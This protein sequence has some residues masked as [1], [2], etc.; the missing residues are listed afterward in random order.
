M[1][2]YFNISDLKAIPIY[3]PFN[4]KDS[5]PN[6]INYND[7]PLIIFRHTPNTPSFLNL[8]P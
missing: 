4:A 7:I 1:G 3:S 2:P 6:F 8:F 5:V